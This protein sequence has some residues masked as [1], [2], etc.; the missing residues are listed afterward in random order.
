MLPL[1]F[2]VYS[3]E[4]SLKESIRVGLWLGFKLM[5][6][7]RGRGLWTQCTLQ[8]LIHDDQKQPVG[9]CRA[10]V[11][12]DLSNNKRLPY[13]LFQGQSSPNQ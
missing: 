9:R 11:F 7:I 10:L 1:T 4:H 3:L 5:V 12:Y 2:Q 8:I 6:R 13:C